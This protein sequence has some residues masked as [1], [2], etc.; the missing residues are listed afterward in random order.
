LVIN[1]ADKS[2]IGLAGPAIVQELH[3]SPQ[4]FGFLGS[5]FFF[6]FAISGILVGFLANRI[7]AR[8]PLLVMVLI[9]SLV[10]FPMIGTVSLEI[11]IASRIILGASEGPATPI[12][13]HAA[14]KWFP[15]PM[16]GVPTAIIAQGAALGVIIAFPVLTLIIKHYSWHW[17]F[18]ALGITGLVWGFLW[19]VFGSEGTLVDAPVSEGSS[20]GQRVPYR[21]LLTCPS[22]LAM[23][24]AGFASYWGL[25]LALTWFPSYLAL[26]L[27]FSPAA[28]G[29]LATLPWIGGFVVI[30]TGGFISQRL[31]THGRSSRL[32][33]GLFPAVTMILGGCILPLIGL[34]PD[35]PIKIA[36]LVCG[37]AIGSTIY[38]TIPVMVSE[39]T[40]QPQRAGML[41]VVNSVITLAGAIAP[42]VMG[43]VIQHSTNVL[44]GYERGFAI[45]G[46]LLIVGGL[47]AVLFVRP[48]IDRKRLAAHAMPDVGLRP[49]RT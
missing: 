16:R 18:G 41:A 47:I 24:C 46:G 39:L 25:A 48:D 3:L 43:S 44:A 2:V 30:I 12:A 36:L 1:F 11:L 9:W 19:L 28:A 37:A 15:D 17:A 49:T 40:P 7:Q 10:Q 21:H 31:K 20:V 34:T 33:R 42:M 8:W 22:I 26:G 32:S 14:Y 4:Q 29:N 23:T 35:A 27:G 13:Q 45:L 5:S 38:V 6:L